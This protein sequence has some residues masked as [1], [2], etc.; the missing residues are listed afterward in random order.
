LLVIIQTLTY[1]FGDMLNSV[2]AAGKV[3]EYLDRKPLVSTDGKLKPDQL[4]GHV[5]YCHLNFAYPAN[6]SKTVLQVK[7]MQIL[8]GFNLG[9]Y[10]S[11]KQNGLTFEF[12]LCTDWIN[13]MCYF[14]LLFN[15]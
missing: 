4:K 1:I 6:P 10:Q 3:F 2:V 5:S 12:T 13:A 8:F 15:V 9:S 11:K 7:R 14:A